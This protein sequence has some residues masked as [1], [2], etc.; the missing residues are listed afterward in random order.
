MC[1]LNSAGLC[2]PLFM[3]GALSRN[4]FGDHLTART[5]VCFCVCV[6]WRVQQFPGA[7]RIVQD[8][9]SAEVTIKELQERRIVQDDRLEFTVTDSA[10]LFHIPGQ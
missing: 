2:C 10:L 9:A 4:P 6:P 7:E 5:T 1:L 3:P 8:V